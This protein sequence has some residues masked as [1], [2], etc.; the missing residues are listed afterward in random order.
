MGDSRWVLVV[1]DQK[2]VRRLL[3]EAFHLVGVPVEVAASGAEAL[4]KLGRREYSLMLLD[5]RMPAMTGLE[6]LAEARRRGHRLPVILMSAYEDLSLI[7]E[8]GALDI[9]DHLIKPFD[10]MELTQKITRWR[11]SPFEYRS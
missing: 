11:A 4:E 3:Y 8:A 5:V 6:A 2:G 7:K 1:D 10:V 9:L